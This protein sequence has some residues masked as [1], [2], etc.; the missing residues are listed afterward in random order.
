MACLAR[1]AGRLLPTRGEPGGDG[2]EGDAG[3]GGAA[4]YDGAVSQ[5]GLAHVLTHAVGPVAGDDLES[6]W[7]GLH[8]GEDI[9]PRPGTRRIQYLEENAAAADIGL[10]DDDMTRIDA[11]APAGSAAGERGS[12]RQISLLDR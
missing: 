3:D 6:V 7:L 10:T 1:S 9:I 5:I 8:K 12:E 11:I 2:S 4:E